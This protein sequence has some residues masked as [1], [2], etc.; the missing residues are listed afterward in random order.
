MKITPL[1]SLMRRTRLALHDVAPYVGLLGLPG[2]TFIAVATWL[3]SRRS[4]RSRHSPGSRCGQRVSRRES[5][6]LER[7]N[8]E[9]AA[10][11][12]ET[13]T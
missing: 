9:Q 12:A 3:A 2:G 7:V 1:P 13:V 6:G 4:S 5:L 11:A 10:A 8:P